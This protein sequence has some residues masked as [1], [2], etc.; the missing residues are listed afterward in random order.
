[1]SEAD[2]T[3]EV[4]PPSAER[5]EWKETVRDIFDILMFHPG[6]LTEVERRILDWIQ[7]RHPDYFCEAKTMAEWQKE[8]N[9]AKP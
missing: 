2:K 5:N 1:M 9:D 7:N 6:A 4:T 3:T 8:K